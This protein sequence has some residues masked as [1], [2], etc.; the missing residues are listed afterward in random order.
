MEAR[1]GAHI[2][3]TG[4]HPHQFQNIPMFQLWLKTGTPST[5]PSGPACSFRPVRPKT[6]FILVRVAVG[7]IFTDTEFRSAMKC[8]GVRLAYLDGTDFAKF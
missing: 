1:P 3:V 5:K 7:K 8:Q 4:D 2:G 6:S